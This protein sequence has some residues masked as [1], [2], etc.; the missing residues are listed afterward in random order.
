MNRELLKKHGLKITPQRLA[1]LDAM[2]NLHDH[3]MAEC[4][5][6]FI[7]KNHPNIATGTVYKTLDTFVEKVIIK[8]VKTDRDVMRYDAITSHHHHLYCMESDRIEDYVDEELNKILNEYFINK[9]IPNFQIE[10]IKLQ[11]SGKFT[12]TTQK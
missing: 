9:G 2:N 5:I 3:P 4:I 10:E 11:L 7:R 6:E 1:V 12:D 8:R